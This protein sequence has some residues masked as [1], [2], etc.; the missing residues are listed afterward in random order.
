MPPHFAGTI[1]SFLQRFIF[2]PFISVVVPDISV[3]QWTVFGSGGSDAAPPELSRADTY[4]FHNGQHGGA[5]SWQI[6]SRV[7]D[8]KLGH[9]EGKSTTPLTEEARKDCVAKKKAYLK[10]GFASHSDVLYWC[11][12]IIAKRPRIATIVAA[13]FC[14]INS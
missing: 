13:R 11:L 1:D 9:F 5:K 4:N 3:A 8:G 10:D 7:I 14:E 2:T 6:K 12:R